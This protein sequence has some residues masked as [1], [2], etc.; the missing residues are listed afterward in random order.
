MAYDH[1]TDPNTG[2]VYQYTDHDKKWSTHDPKTNK[3][4]YLPG[5]PD[6][7]G[8]SLDPTTGLPVSS[9]GSSVT[10]YTPGQSLASDSGR[11]DLARYESDPAGYHQFQQQAHDLDAYN[12]A[13]G[14]GE[15]KKDQAPG[16]FR[17]PN[18]GGPGAALNPNDPGTSVFSGISDYGNV[19]KGSDGKYGPSNTSLGSSL[20]GPSRPPPGPPPPSPDIVKVP[21]SASGPGGAL[22]PNRKTPPP[23]DGYVY[24]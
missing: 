9:A 24:L 20:G 18:S 3:L 10:L 13:N 6:R 17:L 11:R 7:S 19:F 1:Y 5:P 12:K 4:I 16:G 14:L 8:K 2:Q 15:Y 21:V 23:P 22:D